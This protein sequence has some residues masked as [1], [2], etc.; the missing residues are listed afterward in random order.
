MTYIIIPSD[1]TSMRTGFSVLET[2]SHPIVPF[3][4]IHDDYIRLADHGYPPILTVSEFMDLCGQ[5]Y[6]TYISV[7][8]DSPI[9]FCPKIHLYI[10]TDHPP[11]PTLV[12]REETSVLSRSPHKCEVNR[13]EEFEVFEYKRIIGQGVTDIDLISEFITEKTVHMRSVVGLIDKINIAINSSVS[14]SDP[15]LLP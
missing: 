12:D 13:H 5:E 11:C 1:M 7:H 9:W 8:N 2:A 10:W 4:H 6:Y 15:A 14:T 3:V